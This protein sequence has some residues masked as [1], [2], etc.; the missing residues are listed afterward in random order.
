MWKPCWHRA[1][2]IFLNNRDLLPDGGRFF[3][4]GNGRNTQGSPWNPLDILTALFIAPS[5]LPSYNIGVTRKNKGNTVQLRLRILTEPFRQKCVRKTLQYTKYSGGFPP[6]SDANS[7]VRLSCRIVR[8]CPC[9]TQSI[10]A[11]SQQICDAKFLAK[12][13]CR[14]MRYCLYHVPA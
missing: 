3:V 5:P 1:W 6:F 11:F 14:I 10:P 12:S 4:R 7:L 13:P 8:Y 2:N 9:N